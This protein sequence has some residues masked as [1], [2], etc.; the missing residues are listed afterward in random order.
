[1]NISTDDPKLTAYALGELSESQRREIE[2]EL[3]RSPELRAVVEEI[4]TT[5]TGLIQ[6]FACESPAHSFVDARATMAGGTSGR[7]IVP[8]PNRVSFTVIL[9]A[10]A[11]AIAVVLAWQFWFNQKYG[12]RPVATIE[13]LTNTQQAFLAGNS[14][15]PDLK[16]TDF[17]EFE[18][19]LDSPHV[20][21]NADLSSSLSMASLRF[22]YDSPVFYAGTV[23]SD[24]PFHFTVSYKGKFQPH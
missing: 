9:A 21:P 23:D 14:T 24:D 19:A 8:F 1:M 6:E 12:M 3:A 10:M 15:A 4:R 2:R 7:N 16:R 20:G 11:A 18:I 5:A 13:P 22:A 17:R